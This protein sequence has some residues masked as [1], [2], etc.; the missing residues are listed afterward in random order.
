MANG[1]ELARVLSSRKLSLE[2]VLEGLDFLL[3]LQILFSQGFA[4]GEFIVFQHN[5]EEGTAF[6]AAVWALI[7][8]LNQR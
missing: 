7:A 1:G 4:G 6:P 2:L 3:L 8:G 5:G